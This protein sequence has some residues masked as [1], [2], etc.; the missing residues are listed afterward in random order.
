MT[1]NAKLPVSWGRNFLWAV[2]GSEGLAEQAELAGRGGQGPRDQGNEGTEKGRV[3][4]V[5][6]MEMCCG[7]DE[8]AAIVGEVS[9]IG[10]K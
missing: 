1:K 6:A 4:G 8:T 2:S 5:F 9:A 7:C 10:G 3:G